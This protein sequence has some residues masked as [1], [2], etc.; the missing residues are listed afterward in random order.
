[1]FA[2]QWLYP[3]IVRYFIDC[4]MHIPIR[5]L[6]RV[7]LLFGGLGGAGMAQLV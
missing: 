3:Y 4:N 2:K 1:M 5:Y 7:F 6:A